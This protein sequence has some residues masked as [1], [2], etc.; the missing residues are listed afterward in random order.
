MWGE[1]YVT[2]IA[3]TLKY[4][5]VAVSVALS[6]TAK[7]SLYQSLLT[8]DLRQHLTCL[9][10]EYHDLRAKADVPSAA[11]DHTLYQK[12][13]SLEPLVRLVA[14]LEAK[15]K[16]SWFTSSLHS[17]ITISVGDHRTTGTSRGM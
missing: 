3:H 2:Y 8:T 1:K 7:S 6:S 17:F 13:S 11:G 4:L 14:R 9:V 10:E 12:M 15:E 5:C 16:A